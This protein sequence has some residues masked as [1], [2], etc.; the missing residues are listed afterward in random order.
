VLG[1]RE[2]SHRDDD[3]TIFQSPTSPPL[4]GTLGLRFTRGMKIFTRRLLELPNGI[5]FRRLECTLNLPDDLRCT[6]DLVKACS[7]TLERI[8]IECENPSLERSYPDSIDFSKA[9]RLKEVVFRLQ[10]LGDIWSALPLKTLTSKHRDL[11]QISIYIPVNIPMTFTRMNDEIRRQW[12]QLDHILVRSCESNGTLIRAICYMEGGIEGARKRVEALL[13]KVTKGGI[14]ELV[15]YS[16][17][18]RCNLL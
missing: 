14:F 8:D 4:T 16:V 12:M 7:D 10:A 15:D 13:P 2:I 5:H 1:D 17:A 18:R 3:S 11:R 6:M 9:I